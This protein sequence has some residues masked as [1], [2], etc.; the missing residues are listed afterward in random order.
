M[1]KKLYSFLGMAMKAGKLLSGEDACERALKAGK[2]QLVIVA[3]DSSNNTK[4]KF[5]D[6]CSHRNVEIR[7]FGEK[8][9]IG[10]YIGKEIRSVIAV[11]DQGFANRMIEM[12]N[13]IGLEFGGGVIGKSKGI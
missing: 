4:K 13:C 10:R 3:Q 2:I 7:F 6:M 12:M 5:T 1:D 8:E 11:L 9:L